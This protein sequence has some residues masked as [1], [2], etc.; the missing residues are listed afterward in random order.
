MKTYPVAYEFESEPGL[1]EMLEVLN[2]TAV[3]RW[4]LSDS[5]SYGEYLSAYP[6]R[7]GATKLKIL[8]SSPKYLLDICFVSGDRENRMTREMLEDMIQSILFP[9]TSARNITEGSG[10]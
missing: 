10:L 6:P 7:A 9:A 4:R 8:G 5:D 3:W 1:R 2:A